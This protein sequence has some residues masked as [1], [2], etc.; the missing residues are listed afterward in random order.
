MANTFRGFQ[1]LDPKIT[2]GLVEGRDSVLLQ[3]A[4]RGEKQRREILDRTCDTCGGQLTPRLPSDP[5][6]VFRGVQVTLLAYCERCK[7]TR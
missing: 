1:T 6:K 3:E 4:E 5:K 2:R 7:A